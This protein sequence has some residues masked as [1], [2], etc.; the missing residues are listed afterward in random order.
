MEPHPGLDLRTLEIK[1]QTETESQLLNLLQYPGALEFVYYSNRF[2]PGSWYSCSDFSEINFEGAQS[3]AVAIE[4]IH[5]DA[6]QLPNLTVGVSI[7]DFR[8][9]VSLAFQKT[10]SARGH[11]GPIPNYSCHG[12]LPL[13]AVVGAARS[14]ISIPMARYPALKKNSP[15]E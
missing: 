7:L 6:S 9:M 15:C 4:E 12:S 8:D 2:L 10:E 14:A 1:T 13:A 11:K 3:F 5:R